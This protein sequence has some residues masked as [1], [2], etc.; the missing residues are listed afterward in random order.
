MDIFKNTRTEAEIFSK[1]HRGERER[2]EGK[3][4]HSVMAHKRSTSTA[5]AGSASATVGGDSLLERIPENLL[6]EIFLKLEPET[7]SSLSSLACVSRTL[8]SSVN[9]VLSSFSSVDLSVSFFYIYHI[10]HCLILFFDI[11]KP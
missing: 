9:N 1:T 5:V 3:N 10:A 4:G 2:E 8:Q 6:N 7:L 11:L